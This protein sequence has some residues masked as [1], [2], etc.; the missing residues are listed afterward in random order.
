MWT[1]LE[2]G[3]ECFFFLFPFHQKSGSMLA[4]LKETRA[5]TMKSGCIWTS[6]ATGMLTDHERTTI[7][8]YFSRKGLAPIHLPRNKAGMT[9]EATIHSHLCRGHVNLCFHEQAQLTILTSTCGFHQRG[10]RSRA[11][12]LTRGL[13]TL[14]S[15][16]VLFHSCHRTCLSHVH[17]T[18]SSPHKK[19][20]KQP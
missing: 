4:S 7:I 9:T 18:I 20:S 3:V 17:T 6:S 13:S 16:V 8:V 11:F 14:G 19:T 10:S 1:R 15:S 5:A 12:D 2:L